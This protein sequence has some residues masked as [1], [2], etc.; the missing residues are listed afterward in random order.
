M[1]TTYYLKM[2][3]WFALLFKMTITLYCTSYSHFQIVFVFFIL[4]TLFTIEQYK[5]SFP[6]IH[7]LNMT[8]AKPSSKATLCTHSRTKHLH[9]YITSSVYMMSR[10]FYINQCDDN[11][12]IYCKCANAISSI[13]FIFKWH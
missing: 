11:Y 1:T 8:T 5:F 4:T 13:Q 9:K 7:Y 2:V 10:V 12:L 6:I 3:N